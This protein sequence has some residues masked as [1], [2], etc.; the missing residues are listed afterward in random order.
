MLISNGPLDLAFSLYVFCNFFTLSPVL[1]RFPVGLFVG[2]GFFC[3]P[4]VPVVFVLALASVAAAASVAGTA[5]ADAFVF[6]FFLS[7]L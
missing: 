5:W 4:S 3:F 7:L 2:D 1:L 6:V